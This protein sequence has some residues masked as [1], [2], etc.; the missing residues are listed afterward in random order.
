MHFGGSARAR[1]AIPGGP[2][3]PQME[4]RYRKE[5]HMP[6]LKGPVP[7]VQA[8]EGP[9]PQL[10]KKRRSGWAVLAAGALV[11]SLFAVGAA[12]AAALDE[13][14]KPNAEAATSACVGDA[15]DD[16][17]FSDVSEM[18][19]L[20]A[21]I[22]CLAYYA[23][24]VGYGDGNFGPEDD[25]TRGQMV[26]FMERAADK[27][28]ADAEAVV[29]DFAETGSDP[30]TRADM[31]LLIARLLVASTN[32]ES[33][34]NVTNNDDGTFTVSTVTDPKN[35]DYFADARRSLNRV[36]DS[37][38]SALYE[39]GVAKGTGMGYF[40]PAASVSRAEMA[41]FITRALAHTSAR[42]AGVSI[43]S[44]KPGEVIVSVRDANFRPVANA[45]LDV[46]SARAD[47]VDEAF[48]EDGSCYTPR[49]TREDGDM[50]GVC[51]IDALDPVTGL[52]G[53]HT[54]SIM[55]NVKAGGTT[56]WAWTGEHDDEVEDGGEGLASINLT[57]TAPLT[58]DAAKVTTDMAMGV[59]RAAF[60][61][62]VTVTLQLIDT[63]AGNGDAGPTAG[64]TNYTV[65][66]RRET[67]TN[68]QTDDT[69]GAVTAGAQ[70]KTHTL[71]VDASGK[72]AF[73]ITADDPDATDRN[74]PDGD[75]AADPVVPNRI[76]RV[77]VTFSVAP[78]TANAGPAL[79][80]ELSS[81]AADGTQTIT[82]SDAASVVSNATVEGRADYLMA[83]SNGS[84]SNVVTVTV[85]DQYGHPMRNQMVRLSSTHAPVGADP[86]N[87][88][89]FPV[90][91]R[92]DSSGSVRIGYTRVGG[93]S[94]ETVVAH[95][96][97]DTAA[98]GT[99][100]TLG[101]GNRIPAN[102][103][104]DEDGQ[105]SV[106]WV[107]ALTGATLTAADALVADTETNTLIIADTT[108]GP[109]LV[110][111]DDNDQ[112]IVN[113]D[114]VDPALSSVPITMAAFEQYLAADTSN[115]DNVGVTSYDATDSSDVAIF[116]LTVEA[117][118]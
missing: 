50:M 2:N 108:N 63:T 88:S 55:V 10:V 21:E 44:D 31:A 13:D 91:R 28:G 87:A 59:S 95:N 58:A 66:E 30:V 100:V 114:T 70:V 15:T 111:Y 74:N 112:F 115:N 98:D 1:R 20:R 65:V 117:N 56:V 110:R 102:T 3:L 40:S 54:A 46:F 36:S 53:D 109:Q 75:S 39:L 9:M 35:W 105:A 33:P 69:P 107:S 12:P 96:A 97:A 11:A 83:P 8:K 79:N 77:R 89:T 118:T 6:Q 68:V 103:T 32:D 60:G 99:A 71:T 116:T 4:Y 26:L 42:P 80:A 101:A 81:T 18:N 27:A 37:A 64:N 85:V 51:K 19:A 90:A 104:E 47:Q 106:Y 61:S 38:V 45:P 92:T 29:G 62:T 24:T 17:M 48:S 67:D 76:D 86:A 41:A 57:E 7:Q 78:A 72:A 82:F 113:D 34:I 49:L 73:T 94:V 25:V 22:N 93:A 84:A 23:V 14:S 5:G 52:S 43:Q 16:W